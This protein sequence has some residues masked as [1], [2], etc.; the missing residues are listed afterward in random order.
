M[1]SSG[2]IHMEW[3]L[4]ESDGRDGVADE[5]LMYILL[6]WR[7]RYPSAYSTLTWSVSS[8]TAKIERLH[9]PGR[10]EHSKESSQTKHKYLCLTSHYTGGWRESIYQIR[11]TVEGSRRWRLGEEAERRIEAV[12]G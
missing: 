2:Y 1:F 3:R 6:G 8:I 12:W 7:H 5:G 11:G 10:P 4:G 9:L